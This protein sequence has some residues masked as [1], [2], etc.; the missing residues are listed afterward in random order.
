M[1]MSGFGRRL[2]YKQLI[3]NIWLNIW[4]YFFNKNYIE[5]LS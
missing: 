5:Y 3:V 1:I 4:F 2:T